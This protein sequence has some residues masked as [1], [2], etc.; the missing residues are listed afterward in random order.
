[1][2]KKSFVII[3]FVFITALFA[4]TGFYNNSGLREDKQNVTYQTDMK[5]IE[6]KVANLL[7]QM[8]LEEK[9][10]QMTQVDYNAIKDNPQDIAK[11]FIGSVLWGGDS[12][13]P[14]TYPKTWLKISNDLQSYAFKTR[15]KIP[16]ILGIDAVHGHNNVNGAT[17]FPHNIGLGATRDAELVEKIGKATAAEIA[18]TGINWSF[19]PCIAVARNEKWGRTY[20]SFGET[21]DIVK[22]LG[23]AFIKGLQEEIFKDN[24]SIVACAK[25][26]LGDGGTFNGVDQGNVECSKEELF[27][28]HL[29]PYLEAIK[30][31]VGT[32]MISYS[33]WNGVKMHSNKYLITEVLKKQLGFNGF[34]VSDWA[35]IDQLG[36]DYKDDIEKSINAGLDMIM[37]PNKPNEKNNYVQF[38]T[39]LKE[40]V[41]EGKVSLDRINDAVKRILTVKYKIGLFNRT[42]ADTTLLKKI[43]SKEHR[44]LA[45]Q[46]VRQSLV[47]LKNEK[48]ILPLAKN[49]K[50]LHVSGSAADDI[51]IQCGG[52]TITWQ[53]KP[54]NVIEGGTTILTAIKK[55]VSPKT[56]ITYSVDGTGAKGSDAAIVVVG[57]KPYAEMIGDRKSLYLSE[58]DK[59]TIN[60]LKA[61]GVPFVVL[62]LSGRPLIIND[63][64]EKADAFIAAWLP[65]TEGDGIADVLFGDFKPTGKLPCSWPKSMDQIPINYNDKNYEPLFPYSFGLSY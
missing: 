21:P 63:E 40:L 10:G 13:P 3:I 27:S 51:G 12:E 24:T 26:Y 31:D 18:A 58:E 1:M 25:H 56:Q 23:A 57:E 14:D 6:Q 59:N 19:A 60:N 42:F 46:A 9:I 44:Q 50:R 30:N 7:S 61:S 5:V 16:L 39:Y 43:G 32:I 45:R 34:A 17:I 20:E 49:L 55:A 33:S 41:N 4:G 38:V 52:W 37:I 8:T 2:G 28:I 65:G 54:G 64:L 35:A 36:D 62:L 47:L 29:P 15:L 53:G 48:K 22:N 11:Y